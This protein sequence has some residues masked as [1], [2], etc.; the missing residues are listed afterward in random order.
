M[1]SRVRHGNAPLRHH[2]HEISIAQPVGILPTDAQLN[3]LGIEAASAVYGILGY[4]NAP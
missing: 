1:N 4:E 3:D 2:R